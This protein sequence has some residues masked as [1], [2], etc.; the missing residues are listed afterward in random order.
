MTGR[1]V[2]R[3]SD[4][5]LPLLVRLEGFEGEGVHH[6]R[7]ALEFPAGRVRDVDVPYVV[8]RDAVVVG[9]GLARFGE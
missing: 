7:L 9:T 2:Q 6:A 5:A 4:A 1:H 8:R 3:R